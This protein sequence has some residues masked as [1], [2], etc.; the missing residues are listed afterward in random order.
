MKKKDL[1]KIEELEPR[2]EISAWADENNSSCTNNGC[3]N[4]SCADE[5][6]NHNRSCGTDPKKV[7]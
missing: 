1:F 7:E 5:T 4:D 2:L 3:S 6:C